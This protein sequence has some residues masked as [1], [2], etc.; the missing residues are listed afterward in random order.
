MIEGA[1]SRIR[2]M[3]YSR[4]VTEHSYRHPDYLEGDLD[5]WIRLG[6]AGYQQWYQ[7]IDF[8][9]GIEAHVTVPPNWT[10]DPSANTGAGLDRWNEIIKRNLPD[11]RGMRVLDLGCNVGL[12]SI[13][14][15]RM[16]AREV[17]GVDRD[18]HIRQ[19]TGSLPRVDL[20]SQANFVKRAFELRGGITFPVSYKA[21]DFGDLRSLQVLGRFDLVLA[22]NVVYHELD[23]A[24]AL[25]RLL[26]GMTNEIV[27]QSSVVHPPPIQRWASPGWS[28]QVLLQNGFT[29]VAVDSPEEYL[30]PVITGS[31]CVDRN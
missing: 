11:V 13:E 16:G 15:A 5:A 8:G 17:V 19:R 20:I 31:R 22:L 24:P 12:F 2:S 7:H 30:Q 23:R 14:L 10:P 3:R 1:L 28:V 9:K 26:S 6:I 21:I 27:L 18:M 25:I 4:A 29:R